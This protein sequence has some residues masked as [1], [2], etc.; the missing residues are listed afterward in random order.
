[1]AT[2]TN[3]TDERALPVSE[4]PAIRS[5]RA[6]WTKAQAALDQL[7][8]RSLEIVAILG[9]GRTP[10]TGPTPSEDDVDRAV[11]ERAEILPKLAQARRA[12]REAEGVYRTLV[13]TETT[14]ESEARTEARRPLMGEVFAA[15]E[16]LN[17][18]VK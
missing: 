15:A 16:R 10:R 5:A 7:Q 13:V 12:A 1:M 9:D 14:R 6:T 3:S 8:A 4:R 2:M 18:A 17:A 11:V